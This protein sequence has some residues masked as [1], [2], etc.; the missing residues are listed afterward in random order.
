MFR[1]VA[2]LSEFT[3]GDTENDHSWGLRVTHIITGMLQELIVIPGSCI[4]IVSVYFS[5][6]QT[7]NLLIVG[8]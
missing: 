4:H 7:F 2:F 8:D 1:L 5:C 6:I 3:N